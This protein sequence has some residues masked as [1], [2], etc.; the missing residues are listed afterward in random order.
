MGGAHLHAIT[1]D[2]KFPIFKH[3]NTTLEV[4]SVDASGHKHL[5]FN[6]TVI[7]PKQKGDLTGAGGNCNYGATGTYGVEIVIKKD[8]DGKI[9]CTSLV[10]TS[11]KIA[12]PGFVNIAL[13]AVNFFG[14]LF[15]KTLPWDDVSSYNTGSAEQKMHVELA[16]EQD[17]TLTLKTVIDPAVLTLEGAAKIMLGVSN[18]LGIACPAIL[19]GRV[20]L[21]LDK[22]HRKEVGEHK[23]PNSFVR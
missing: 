19:E 17:G 1:N 9:I 16:F 10:G 6:A 21:Q 2:G 12:I 20:D 18:G 8:V 11:G 4:K 13:K 7:T 23:L 15:S 5:R 22:K 14:S 3:E